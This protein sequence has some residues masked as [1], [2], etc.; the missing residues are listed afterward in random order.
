VTLARVYYSISQFQY[1]DEAMCDFCDIKLVQSHV[2]PVTS[3]QGR[4]LLPKF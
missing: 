4:Q 1:P 3:S 2:A